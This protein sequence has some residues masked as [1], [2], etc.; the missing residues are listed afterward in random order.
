MFNFLTML[1]EED[2]IKSETFSKDIKKCLTVSL[3]L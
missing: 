2:L 3:F 1:N